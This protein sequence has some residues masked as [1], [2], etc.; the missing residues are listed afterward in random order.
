MNRKTLLA[1]GLAAFLGVPAFAENE[2]SYGDYLKPPEGIVASELWKDS[3]REGREYQHLA[4]FSFDAAVKARGRENTSWLNKLYSRGVD[5]VVGRLIFGG[6]A[7]ATT[8]VVAKREDGETLLMRNFGSTD[9]QANFYLDTNEAPAADFV[10]KTLMSEREI[11]DLIEEKAMTALQIGLA[12]W[13]KV[14]AS[15]AATAAAPMTGGASVVAAPAAG[16]AAGTAAAAAAEALK[17]LAVHYDVGGK[18]ERAVQDSLHGAGLEQDKLDG[19]VVYKVR[20]RSKA[21]KLFGSIALKTDFALRLAESFNNKD[22]LIFSEKDGAVTSKLLSERA[23]EDVLKYSEDGNIAENFDVL[24]NLPGDAASDAQSCF[25]RESLGLNEK[26]FG[27][28]ERKAG[29]VWFADADFLNTFLHPDLKGGFK[30]RVLLKYDSDT[31]LQDHWGKLF[32]ARKLVMLQKHGEDRTRAEYEEKEFSLSLNGRR[33]SLEIFLDAETLVVREVRL[34]A[35]CDVREG[36]L[37]DSIFTRGLAL[38]G[39]GECRMEYH[40]RESDLPKT[41]DGR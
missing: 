1:L 17:G 11:K 20:N 22:Y 32:S 21:S 19:D 38:R 39:D 18:V 4:T 33:T 16:A 37:P 13:A 23:L 28:R 15:A 14:S 36:N 30:G 3:W 34:K 6:S 31:R 41:D 8:A 27:G 26:I 35:E 9:T 40:C 5:E 10:M 12:L 2:N 24:K 25:K 7:N 29:D